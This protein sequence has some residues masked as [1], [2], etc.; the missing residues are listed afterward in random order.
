MICKG[1]KM[2]YGTIRNEK[3]KHLDRQNKP[4]LFKYKP[5]SIVKDTNGVYTSD[6]HLPDET[7]VDINVFNDYS[8]TIKTWQFNKGILTNSDSTVLAFNMLNNYPHLAK[9][10]ADRF[11]SIIVDEAQDTSE[12]QHSIFDKLIENGLKNIEL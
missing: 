10:L 9:A 5:S 1:L 12:I 2:N 7:K 8:K 4:L 3:H 6:W 11:N